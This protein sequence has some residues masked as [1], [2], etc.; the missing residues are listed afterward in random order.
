MMQAQAPYNRKSLILNTL[1]VALTV[2]T[3]HLFIE[4]FPLRLALRCGAD[5]L[6]NSSPPS[7]LLKDYTILIL[8][9]G[10]GMP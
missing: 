3:S 2:P 8:S 1:A 6:E 7:C 5:E 9:Y 10:R 4:T